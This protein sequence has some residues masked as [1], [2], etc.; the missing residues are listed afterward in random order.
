MASLQADCQ[1]HELETLAQTAAELYQLKLK[2]RPH[3][4][5]DR[6]QQVLTAL[7]D[8]GRIRHT[9]NQSVVQIA[10]EAT[11]SQQQQTLLKQNL[12]Q[13]R[14][15]RKGPFDLFDIKIDTEWRSDWK[16][17]RL[18]PHIRPLTGQ[19]VLDIGCGNGYHCWR[20]RGAGAELVVG[21]DPTLLYFMQFQV[22]KHY[23]PHEPVYLL[24]AGM[25][26]LPPRLPEFDTVFSMGVLYHRQSP[27]EHLFALKE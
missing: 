16:W 17:D 20:M 23:L 12:M 11:L 15:W 2:E 8:M 14:P 6:W 10:G 9:L 27:F 22:F 4:D 18:L 19:R 1:Q 24:P 3:G 21:V 25:E 26:D 7:P 5:L 13:L